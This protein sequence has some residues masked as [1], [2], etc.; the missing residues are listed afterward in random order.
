VLRRG[1]MGE[2]GSACKNEK[3]DGRIEAPEIILN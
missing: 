3:E 1:K 2:N